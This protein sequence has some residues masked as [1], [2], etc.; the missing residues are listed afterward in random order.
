MKAT[1]VLLTATDTISERGALYGHPS[2]NQQRIADR[3]S[4]LFQTPIMDYE[5][6]LAMIEV[7]LS[8]IIESPTVEDHYIDLC[9]Y[10]AIACELATGSGE[11]S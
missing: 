4:Q 10:A 6:A 2:I 11:W 7:K 3:W 1:E 8:R 9:G 5:A